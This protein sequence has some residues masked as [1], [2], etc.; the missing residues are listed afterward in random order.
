MRIK[1]GFKVL[2]MSLLPGRY[3]RN[4]LKLR[5]VAV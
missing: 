2:R 5:K 4:C 1:L 3:E